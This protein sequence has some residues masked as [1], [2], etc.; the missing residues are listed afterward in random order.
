M[1]SSPG[2]TGIAGAYVRRQDRLDQ[3]RY[4]VALVLKQI[5]D[6]ILVG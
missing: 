3:G 1:A 6:S 2:P 5:D 4:Q